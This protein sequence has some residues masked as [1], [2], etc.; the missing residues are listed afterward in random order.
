VALPLETHLALVIPLPEGEVVAEGTVRWTEMFQQRGGRRYAN[1]IRFDR[2]TPES[3]DAIV[4][5][6]FW[7]ISP[8]HGQL[9]SMTAKA[10]A[11]EVAA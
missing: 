7:E 6:L 10:Q 4:R 1:G 5:Y 9:L 8:K 11:K 3:Q 2:I